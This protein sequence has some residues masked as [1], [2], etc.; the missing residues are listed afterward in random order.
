MREAIQLLFRRNIIAL[1]DYMRKE[2]DEMG[3]KR[4][5]H[6][7]QKSQE[8]HKLINSKQLERMVYKNKSTSKI[9][10]NKDKEV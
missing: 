6:P 8:R 5:K 1:N 2:V 10:E 4:V 3:E 9:R 7:I